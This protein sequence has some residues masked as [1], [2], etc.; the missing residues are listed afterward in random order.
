MFEGPSRA[1]KRSSGALS[2][3]WMVV[4]LIAAA[5]P[6][7]RPGGPR[8]QRG[9]NRLGGNRFWMENFYRWKGLERVCQAGCKIER[10][11][12]RRKQAIGPAF[13]IWARDFEWF[14]RIYCMVQQRESYNQAPW[15]G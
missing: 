2:G 11:L 3:H 10:G 12:N 9:N 8:R 14:F 4:L 6:L 1:F 13:V 5:R 7:S 15:M